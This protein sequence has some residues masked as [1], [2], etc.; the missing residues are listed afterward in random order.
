MSL[1]CT[2]TDRRC[3]ISSR[4]LQISVAPCPTLSAER[5]PAWVLMGLHGIIW[6]SMGKRRL[7]VGCTRQAARVTR[8]PQSRLAVESRSAALTKIAEIPAS[9]RFTKELVANVLRSI[10]R[11]QS[12]KAGN[13]SY[14]CSRSYGDTRG[15]RVAGNTRFASG[16]PRYPAGRVPGDLYC[17]IAW[18]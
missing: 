16:W 15:R 1:A 11:R 17:A 4:A 2:P 13:G 8:S 9:V 12:C 6:E 10:R 18:H 14:R 5:Q 7:A 3:A